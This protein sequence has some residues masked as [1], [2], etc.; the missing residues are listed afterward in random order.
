[1]VCQ[2]R[3]RIVDRTAGQILAVVEF[4]ESHPFSLRLRSWSGLLLLRK[5]CWLYEGRH[6]DHCYSPFA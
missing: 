4:S 3:H 6:Q 1:M 5:S 2:V